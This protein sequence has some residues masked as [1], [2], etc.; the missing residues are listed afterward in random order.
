[1]VGVVIAVG[2]RTVMASFRCHSPT[3]SLMVA[4]FVATLVYNTTEAALFRILAPAS[5]FLLFAITRSP[6]PSSP[7]IELSNAPAMNTINFEMR[8]CEP[9]LTRD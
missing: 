8:A 2:Y 5:I 1:L 4:Y 6:E 3:A 9:S 7:E